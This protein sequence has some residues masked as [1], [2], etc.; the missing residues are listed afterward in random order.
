MRRDE[1]DEGQAAKREGLAELVAAD[2]PLGPE[3]AAT[4]LRVRRAGFNHMVRLG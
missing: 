4:R 3:Q 2:T 1:A